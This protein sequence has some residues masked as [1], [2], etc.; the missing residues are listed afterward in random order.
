MVIEY[1]TQLAEFVRHTKCLVV[2][3]PVDDKTDIGPLVSQAHLRKV[4]S[5]VDD[6]KSAISPGWHGRCEWNG[7]RKRK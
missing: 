6:G 2:C 1:A 5:F 4:M 7:K 3:D